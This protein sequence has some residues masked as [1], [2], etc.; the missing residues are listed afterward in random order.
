MRQ[1]LTLG[2]RIG[3]IGAP[4]L[5]QVTESY[6]RQVA[7]VRETAKTD[8]RQ[9]IRL[10]N[11]W[12]EMSSRVRYQDEG[13]HDL[14]QTPLLTLRLRRADCEDFSLSKA[15]MAIDAGI[16]KQD[17]YVAWCTHRANPKSRAQSHMVCLIDVHA[18]ATDIHRNQHQWVK[19]TLCLDNIIKDVRPADTRHDLDVVSVI[20]I[21]SETIYVHGEPTLSTS[22]Q[23]RNWKAELADEFARVVNR[24]N[25]PGGDKLADVVHNAI[26]FEYLDIG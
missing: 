4:S 23:L 25:R 16:P 6:Y 21:E 24:I 2:Q 20:N 11:A 15:K 7:K 13:K 14:W 9:A 26:P 19:D 12:W 18:K 22:H 17:V 5:Q 3:L 1:Q 10:I 8:L